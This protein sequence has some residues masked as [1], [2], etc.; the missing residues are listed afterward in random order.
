MF[1]IS[2]SGIVCVMLELMMWVV[3]SSGYSSR[4]MV[5]LIV[6]VLIDVIDMSMLSMVFVSMVDYSVCVGFG[7]S[8]LCVVNVVSCGW[9]INVSDVSSS[10]ILSMSWII[11]VVFGVFILCVCSYYSVSVVVGMLFVVS[12]LVMC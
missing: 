5:M 12:W 10:V 2:V 7:V 4:S 9:K 3:V 8:G 11:C 6:L 1:V